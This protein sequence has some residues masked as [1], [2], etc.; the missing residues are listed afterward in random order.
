VLLD[1][2]G[3][4]FRQRSRTPAGGRPSNGRNGSK[5]TLSL[6]SKFTQKKQSVPANLTIMTGADSQTNVSA[7]GG[8]RLVSRNG[9]VSKTS[10]AASG[11][12]L[13]KTFDTQ[14]TATHKKRQSVFE[15]LGPGPG[16]YEFKTMFPNGPK[17][18]I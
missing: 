10:K 1:D 17:Y 18:P 6:K 4:R 16:A 11:K 5:G 12:F 3:P 2:S 13:T 15:T 8:R 14:S 7:K 9:S